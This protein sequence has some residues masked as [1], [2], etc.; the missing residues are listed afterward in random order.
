MMMLFFYFIF[1]LPQ[2]SRQFEGVLPL[3][4]SII[5]YFLHTG[6]IANLFWV[7]PPLPQITMEDARLRHADDD[8]DD[9]DDGSGLLTCSKGIIARGLFTKLTSPVTRHIFLI[10]CSA[11]LESG[12]DSEILLRISITIL[13]CSVAPSYFYTSQHAKSAWR[14]ST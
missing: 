10:A 11:M 9:D 13:H 5:P 8:D 6:N 2:S 7:S 4:S 1:S 14:F 12:T 3:F